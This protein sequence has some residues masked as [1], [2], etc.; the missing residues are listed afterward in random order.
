MS[1]VHL[2]DNMGN[3]VSPHPSMAVPVAA[4]GVQ[5]DAGKDTVG[6]EIVVGGTLYVIS[7]T[8]NR[9]GRWLFSITGV[10]TTVANVE[11]VC[12]QGEKI[13]IQIP[14]GVTTLYYLQKDQA[15]FGYMVSLKSDT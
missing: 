13:I 2:S 4:S 9:A 5:L 14:Q 12:A 7:T 8:G 6:T 1:E 10:L 15:G 3:R 11:W